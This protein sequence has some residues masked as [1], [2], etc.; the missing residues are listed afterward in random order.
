M[1]T[2]NIDTKSLNLQIVDDSECT[3]SA[4]R[5][6]TEFRHYMFRLMQARLSEI[7]KTDTVEAK[8]KKLTDIVNIPNNFF[9]A[10]RHSV[11]DGNMKIEYEYKGE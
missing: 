8:I 4:S 11:A 10:V 3:P 2:L 9:Q 7:K 1:V 5:Q 6:I